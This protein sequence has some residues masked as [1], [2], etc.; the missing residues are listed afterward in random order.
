M[1]T[2]FLVDTENVANKALKYS[3]LVGEKDIIYLFLGAATVSVSLEDALNLKE[4][5]A[6]K[7][8]IIQCISNG[9]N[10]LDFQLSSYLG[11]L[12]KTA[13][14]THYAIISDDHGYSPLITFWEQQGTKVGVYASIRDAVKAIRKDDIDVE[15]LYN[16]AKIANEKAE[17]IANYNSGMLRNKSKLGKILTGKT[18]EQ[19][20][21]I[22]DSIY[23]LSYDEIGKIVNY[24][25][26]KSE[27][28]KIKDDWGSFSHKK[29]ASNSEETN[30]N[31]K[32]NPD[33]GNNAGSS[34]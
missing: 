6:Q 19:R 16:D 34:A 23:Y 17:E 24:S 18:K 9:S 7:I 32:I 20:D 26:T 4:C 21:R 29:L 2:V 12:I 33:M 22:A 28:R 10:A 11:Y 5:K 14:K 8:E 25:V 3:N 30:N 15:E 1:R 31:E 27:L 13:P